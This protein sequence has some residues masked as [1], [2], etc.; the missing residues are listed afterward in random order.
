MT[1]DARYSALLAFAGVVALTFQIVATALIA[2]ISFIVSRGVRQR[3][4]L[5]WS[6]GWTCYA[7][8]LVAILLANR[9]TAAAPAFYFAYFFLE[10]A[11]VLLIF[12]ACRYTATNQPLSRTSWFVLGVAAVAVAA[13]LV[14][15]AMM[16][17]YLSFAIHSG[18]ISLCWAA[19]LVALLPALRRSDSG[20]G[21]RIVAVGLAL[22]FV[23]YLQH[24]PTAL[25]AA[26]RHLAVDPNYYTVTSL[27]DGML[28][29]VLGFGTVIAI[30]DYVRSELQ[31]AN[32]RLS[33]AH[34]R[35][36]EALNLDP[37]TGARS[38]YSFNVMFRGAAERRSRGGAV[39]MV[40]LDGLKSINDT[41]GHGAGDNAISAVAEGLRTI[42]R[43]DDRV[44]RWGGDEFVAVMMGATED[45]A[46]KRMEGLSAAIN[47]AAREL[48]A[49]LEDVSVSYGVAGFA[50]S[51]GIEA[52]IEAADRAM[53]ESKSRRAIR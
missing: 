25:N 40:D 16:S 11:A 5:Y 33:S 20:P 24:F 30:V 3:L 50:A 49:K 47:R 2:L 18:V 10:Y 42:V 28:E 53:Y 8:A 46:R 15:P 37:L 41:L 1:P 51:A 34:E 31:R 6:A 12:A 22:L 17:F 52:A 32:V 27:V 29:F 7:L 45:L 19:C 23:D 13:L 35:A 9:L 21:V 39:V 14:Q 26:M 4:M 38:R 44:Y 48:D 36:Q 43:D